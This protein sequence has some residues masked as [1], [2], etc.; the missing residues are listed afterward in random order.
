M[1]GDDSVYIAKII[2]NNKNNY[3]AVIKI[4][5]E[6][7]L[8]IESESY[9]DKL[10]ETTVFEA[11]PTDEEV[12]QFANK[13]DEIIS[14][15]DEI[16]LVT[17]EEVHRPLGGCYS[18]SYWVTLEFERISGEWWIFKL[19]RGRRVRL[20]CILC[21]RHRQCSRNHRRPQ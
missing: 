1:V 3:D 20:Q 12:E 4:N 9:C 2:Y 18:N 7:E 14:K 10:N 6:E 19:Y 8:R 15:I 5:G 17:I 21:L 13:I 11:P 16:N